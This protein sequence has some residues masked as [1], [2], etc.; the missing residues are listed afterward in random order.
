MAGNIAFVL[1][2][3]F[4]LTEALENGTITLVIWTTREF[5]SQSLTLLFS[6]AVADL[7]V[8]L[9]GQPSFAAYKIAERLENFKVYCTL[10]MTQFFMVVESIYGE[11]RSVK[12]AYGLA[13]TAVFI[14][15]FVIPVIYCWKMT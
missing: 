11:T 4:A 14:N 1:R 2:S 9:I 12:L 5:H 8:G 3:I 6:L 13:T 10:R 15:S 7:L